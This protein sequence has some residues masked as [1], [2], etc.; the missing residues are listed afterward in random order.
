[1]LRSTALEGPA[2]AEAPVLVGGTH[3]QKAKYLGRMTE[4]P[5]IAAYCVTEPTCGSGMSRKRKEKKNREEE[6]KMEIM[7]MTN[8]PG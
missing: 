6:R 2:L 5:L 1:M 7:T 3:E 4:E 8:Y